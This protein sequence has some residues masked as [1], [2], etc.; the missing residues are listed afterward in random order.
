MLASLGRG[1]SDFDDLSSRL[2]EAGYETIALEPAEA[3]APGT[4]M[5]ELAQGVLDELDNRGVEVFHLVGH[6]FGNRLARMVSARAPQRV[7]TLT[8]LAA[9]GY[10]PIEPAVAHSLL[11]CFDVSASPSE[12]LSA[13]A[14]AFFA[15]GHDAAIW[16]SGW[17]AR[18]ATYQRAAL[19][20]TDPA[21]WWDATAPRVLVV[22]GLDDRIAPPGNGRH[23]V[24]NHRDVATLV[25]IANAGHALIVEQPGAVARAVVNFLSVSTS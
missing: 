13:I 8:L 22:Q 6:A 14:H 1:A 16:E 20:A 9:G 10:L 19:E 12:H 24:A 18:V 11:Q 4:T 25:E 21:L 7:L 17:D 5:V 23:Y 3:V 2:D 15:D